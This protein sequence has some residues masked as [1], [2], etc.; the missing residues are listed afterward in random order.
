[1]PLRPSPAHPPPLLPLELYGNRI[2]SLKIAGNRFWQFFYLST[3]F[4]QKA[5]Y[6]SIH[7]KKPVNICE[8]ADRHNL[9]GFLIFWY[10][11]LSKI[12]IYYIIFQQIKKKS[13]K[14]SFLMAHPH[15]PPLPLLMSLPFFFLRLYLLRT[16]KVLYPIFIHKCGVQ[17][18]CNFL[19]SD[20]CQC[21]FTVCQFSFVS[22]LK[23]FGWNWEVDQ[24]SL[25]FVFL[26]PTKQK[27]RNFII[28]HY[29]KSL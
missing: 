1:M 23:E 11:V 10:V 22:N 18:F 8:F 9:T 6:L 13:R 2:F 12:Y 5:P 4:G 24:N 29:R 27:I 21:F 17:S 15:L 28:T 19:L 3:I 16:K 7:F 25:K 14:K 20:F 26:D